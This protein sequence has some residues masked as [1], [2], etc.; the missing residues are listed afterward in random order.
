MAT[1]SFDLIGD[2]AVIEAENKNEEKLLVDKIRTTYPRIKAVLKKEKETSGTYRRRKYRIVFKDRE[3]VK[4]SG[5]KT[6]E[7]I[8]IEHG[9][10]YKLDVNKVFFNPRE[11]TIR[12]T[13][14]DM[15]KPGERVLVMF[16]GIA[17]YPI[18]IAKKTKCDVV[19]VE[20]NPEA[21]KYARKNV[22]LNKVLNRVQLFQID[23]RKARINGKFD[24]IIMP[25]GITAYKYLDVAFSYC[26]SGGIIHLYGLGERENLYGDIEDKVKKA[27]GERNV[28]IVERRAISLYSPARNKVCLDLRVS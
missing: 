12:K 5:M 10:R 15:I 19:G 23:V 27:T 16:S 7:T 24:R 18:L 3:K 21:V 22:K 26:K 17:P 25:L 6:S 28:K 11:A 9:C 8:H 4:E 14:T 20:I 1:R 2:I 13:I